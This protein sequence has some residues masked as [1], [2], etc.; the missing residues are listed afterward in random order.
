MLLDY[1]SGDSIYYT[2]FLSTIISNTGSF[3]TK[4]V[5]LFIMLNLD[6]SNMAIEV[7]QEWNK[8]NFL[9]FW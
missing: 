2:L 5:I 1:I 6:K 9:Q 7:T 4:E 3:I 8:V